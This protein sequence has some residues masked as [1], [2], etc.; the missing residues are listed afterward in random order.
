MNERCI[1]EYRSGLARDRYENR[2]IEEAR[3]VIVDAL[4]KKLTAE[5]LRVVLERLDTASPPDWDVAPF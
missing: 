2:L 5:H 4:G 3:S 1:T